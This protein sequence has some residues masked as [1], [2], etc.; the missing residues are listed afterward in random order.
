MAPAIRLEDHN[1]AWAQ[2]F[3][4]KKKHLEFILEDLPI[5]AIE[6]VGSTSIPNLRA[7]P[8]IDIDIEISANDLASVRGR[9]RGAGYFCIGECG[10]PERFAFW[11]VSFYYTA[12]MDGNSI[13]WLLQQLSSTDQDT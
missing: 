10:L 5:I 7:K 6:H 13:S 12:S 1:P 4:E 8:I 2:E 9:L 3:A 11:Y